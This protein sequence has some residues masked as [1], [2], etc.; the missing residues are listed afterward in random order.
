MFLPSRHICILINV[1]GS[2]KHWTENRPCS[3]KRHEDLVTHLGIALCPRL[4]SWYFSC[5]VLVYPVY[6]VSLFFFH[7]NLMKLPYIFLISL[8]T[9]GCCSFAEKH[10][11]CVKRH[12]IKCAAPLQFSYLSALKGEG[13]CDVL[14]NGKALIMRVRGV[15][16]WFTRLQMQPVRE[17]A[18][19]PQLRLVHPAKHLWFLLSAW[20]F[21]QHLPPCSRV[22]ES[23]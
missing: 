14:D 7:F 3:G 4:G 9:L 1:N 16:Y 12:K 21:L 22:Q 11:T 6:L 23:L 15:L 13:S 19:C 10:S 8:F 18:A 5:V 2:C 20:A 17:V